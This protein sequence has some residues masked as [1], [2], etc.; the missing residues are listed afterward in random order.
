[1]SATPLQPGDPC[2]FLQTSKKDGKTRKLRC[3]VIE[4]LQMKT[5]GE[6]PLIPV[7]RTINRT[8]ATPAIDRK[9]RKVPQP[10]ILWIKRSLLR[11]L[12]TP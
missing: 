12:P 11:K 6:E 2:H 3:T 5:R 7:V 9:D 4:S 1:M 8:K 10:R